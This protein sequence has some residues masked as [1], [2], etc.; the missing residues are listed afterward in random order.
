MLYLNIPGVGSAVL[1][2]TPDYD[3]RQ[4]IYREGVEASGL[5]GIRRR[6]FNLVAR[7]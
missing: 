3:L 6:W 1:A 5:D 7:K 2:Q 4:Q